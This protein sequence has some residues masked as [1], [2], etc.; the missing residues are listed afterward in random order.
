M[1]MD[2][3]TLSAKKLNESLNK[4]KNVGI[5]EESCVVAGCDIVLRNL[6]PDE[7]TAILRDCEELKNETEFLSTWQ[8]GHVS[9]SIVVLNGV[10]F[11]D[12]D[13][14]EVE[15][16]D[17]KRPGQVRTI[18]LEL[19]NY[20]LK[21]VLSTWG[22]EPLQVAFRKFWDVKELAERKA[23]EGVNFIVP[24]ETTEEKYR[25]LLLEAKECESEL[26]E[27]LMAKILEDAGLIRIST[28]GEIEKALEGFHPEPMAPEPEPA[29][30]PAAAVPEP[31]Q[32]QPLP[33]PPRE[34]QRP[35]DPHRTFQ[36]AVASRQNQAQKA[37]EPAIAVP[38]SPSTPVSARASEIAFIEENLGDAGAD[39]SVPAMEL[40]KTLL[41]PNGKQ[42][43]VVA[44]PF[45]T[46]NEVVSLQQQAAFDPAAARQIL[47]KPPAA[48]LNPRFKPPQRV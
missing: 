6:R 10:D 42:I 15:E 7:Y 27:T 28:K 40:P 41:G 34:P 19:H 11:H 22:Q 13:F 8:K 12:V 21:H 47:D 23:K 44:D 2:M 33:Q 9:R 46:A 24:E 14:V 5:V 36:A 45:T 35:V 17:P 1:R 30:E 43:P 20:L 31:V 16:D 32:A 48:G 37:P 38:V 39:V 3:G 18:K 4:A 29:P 25:R 26:P